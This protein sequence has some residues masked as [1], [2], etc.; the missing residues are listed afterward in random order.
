MSDDVSFYLPDREALGDVDA[1]ALDPDRD[2]DLIATGLYGW[3]LQTFLRLRASGAPVRLDGDPPP[4]GTVVAHVEYVGRLLEEAP[5][6]G[7]LF[8]VS[9]RMDRGPQLMADLEVVQNASSVGPYQVFI[10]FWLQPGLIGRDPSR[11]TRVDVVTFMGNRQSLHDELAS[12]AWAD[13]LS[14][15]G[16]FWDIRI[17]TFVKNDQLQRGHRWHDFS[18]VDVVVALRPRA[19][20][21]AQGKPAS[22]LINAWA[23]GV[24]AILGPETPYRELRRSPLDYIEV[25]STADILAALE[26]LRS[27][28]GLYAAMVANGLARAREFQHDRLIEQWTD[29]LWR[30]VPAR[31]RTYRHRLFAKRRDLRAATRSVRGR[32]AA[33][34]RRA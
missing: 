7:R 11:G 6:P 26:R 23:A 8:V 16:L 27:D 28:P 34:L 24:P 5:A 30:E 9:P 29:L 17:V 14:A 25:E 12:P 13:S 21:P 33:E 1:A 4:S 15:I 31:A 2:A 32:I 22:K 20:W 19:A 10:P 3:I 18:A